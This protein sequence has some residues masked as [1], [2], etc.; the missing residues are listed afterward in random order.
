MWLYVIIGLLTVALL[1]WIFSKRI[2]AQR[3]YKI[4]N[5]SYKSFD[6]IEEPVNFSITTY[7]TLADMY[8]Q[9]HSYAKPKYRDFSYRLSLFKSIFNELNSD[10]FALQEVDKYPEF[11]SY[12]SSIGYRSVFIE[13]GSAKFRDGLV[14][15][16][17]ANKYL[18]IE[19]KRIDYNN[20]WKCQTNRS[21][22]R[23]GIGFIAVFKEKLSKRHLAIACTHFY[24]D[25]EFEYVQ[26][27]QAGILIDELIK[28]KHQYD[29]PAVVCGD[30]NSTPSSNVVNLFYGKLWK[31]TGNQEIDQ[32]LESLGIKPQIQFR[33]AYER[34]EGKEHPKFTNFTDNFKGCIDFVFHTYEIKPKRILMLPSEEEIARE[35]AIP[36]REFPSDHLPLKVEFSFIE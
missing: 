4:Q 20:H 12:F 31:A 15:A 33:S 34:Y 36:N 29:C 10:F 8:T 11:K 24:W 32:E 9:F 21:Y 23:D 6:N 1:Y 13:R 17:K 3:V 25:P 2:L 22:K 14:L 19:S 5:F 35:I 18:Q 16:W 26:Y 27:A 30:C 28:L 7:N